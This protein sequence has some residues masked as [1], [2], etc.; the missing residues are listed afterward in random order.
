MAGLEAV[1]EGSPGVEGG[2]VN[3]RIKDPET[4]ARLRELAEKLR[5]KRRARN[6]NATAWAA[7]RPIYDEVY[8]AWMEA[9]PAR[10]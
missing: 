6:N 4:E 3:T 5:Q 2:A 7:H 1:R 9:D 8:R 10:L